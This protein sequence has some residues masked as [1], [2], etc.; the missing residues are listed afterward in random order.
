MENKDKTRKTGISHDDTFGYTEEPI[1]FVEDI[2]I[3][4]QT[5]IIDLATLQRLAYNLVGADLEEII[6]SFVTKLMDKVDI[7][8]GAHISMEEY[9]K[10]LDDE[11]SFHKTVKSIVEH[12]K[13]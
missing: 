7:E 6:R 13:K 12:N 2:P 11:S 4:R 8:S 1:S 10:L 3:D 5:A 9:L